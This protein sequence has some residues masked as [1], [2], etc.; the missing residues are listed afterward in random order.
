MEPQP[1]PAGIQWWCSSSRPQT[2]G[3]LPW[4]PVVSRDSRERA[5]TRVTPGIQDFPA[6]VSVVTL[7]ILDS[8]VILDT[9]EFPGSQGSALSLGSRVLAESRVTRDLVAA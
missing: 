7:R 6:R 8:P 1:Q 5:A 2:H 4:E 9:L 3:W